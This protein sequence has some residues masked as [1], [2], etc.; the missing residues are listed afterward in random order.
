MSQM[1]RQVLNSEVK[2]RRRRRWREADIIGELHQIIQGKPT[3]RA[4]VAGTI[5]EGRLMRW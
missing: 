3:L 4:G 5:D 1:Y 2:E